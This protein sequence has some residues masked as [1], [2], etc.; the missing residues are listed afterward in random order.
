MNTQMKNPMGEYLL[1]LQMIVSNSEFK[2]DEEANMYETLDSKLNGE[3]YV[4]AMNKTDIFE[5]YQYDGKVVYDMLAKEGYDEK[6]IFILMK[7]PAM[8]P[9]NI[10]QTLLENARASFIARYDEPNKY[11][12]ML[13]GK[14]V[15]PYL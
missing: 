3:A 5:S 10:K 9:S 15:N 1:K 13:S 12:V 8:L 7:N 2:N 4:R 11:Y 6:R 14:S